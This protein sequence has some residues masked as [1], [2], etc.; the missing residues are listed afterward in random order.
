MTSSTSTSNNA[1]TDVPLREFCPTPIKKICILFLSFT[2]AVALLSTTIVILAPIFIAVTNRFPSVLNT[3][4]RGSNHHPSQKIIYIPPTQEDL[5]RIRQELEVS[6]VLP[7]ITIDTENSDN[8]RSAS[9]VHSV[10]ASTEA[11]LQQLQREWDMAKEEIDDLSVAYDSFLERW[12]QDIMSSSRPAMSVVDESA[13]MQY[14]ES[15]LTSLRTILGGQRSSFMDLDRHDMTLLI[16]SAMDELRWLVKEEDESENDAYKTLLFSNVNNTL[17]KLL[18]LDASS[19]SNRNETNHTCHASYLD[20]NEGN[21]SMEFRPTS[22]AAK[23]PSGSHNAI[24][25][26]TAR[27]SDLNDLV[28]AIEISL[29]W[30]DD[31]PMPHPP[32][33]SDEA[34]EDIRSAIAPMATFI[35]KLRRSS[36]ANEKKVRDYWVDRIESFVSDVEDSY[37][38]SNHDSDDDDDDDDEDLLCASSGLVKEMMEEGM[39]AFR[40]RGNLRSELEGVA[41][42]A[43]EDAPPEIIDFLRTELQEANVPK[44]DYSSDTALPQPT[45]TTTSS[46]KVGKKSIAY[47]VDGPWL[48]R[49]VVNWIDYCVDVVS[50]YN[51]KCPLMFL[52][53]S[54][55]VNASTSL[56]PCYTD[57]L[58]SLLDWIVGDGAGSSVGSVLLASVS[59]LVRKIPLPESVGRLKKAGILAGRTRSILEG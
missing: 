41:L 42:R 54:S 12:E 2:V 33:I 8:P 52:C 1:S 47:A 24:T 25:E 23:P 40:K 14:F 26:E 59:K 3:L 11:Q 9:R 34:V 35:E 53:M 21:P 39:E 36:L 18:A 31:E 16:T 32:F 37:A 44:I 45:T 10:I 49:G 55:M 56:L 48:R 50:G 38:G 19:A 28:E 7:S 20:L 4:A 51:G 15:R 58:D 30:H 57:H 43:V 29:S 17:Y 6:D 46:W 13:M 5:D 22:K 27:E